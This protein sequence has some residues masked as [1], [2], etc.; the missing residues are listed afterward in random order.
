[1]LLY[2]N[3]EMGIGLFASSLPA[4]R[5]FYR[6]MFKPDHSTGKGSTP[7]TSHQLAPMG[8]SGKGSSARRDPDDIPVGDDVGKDQGYRPGN[9]ERLADESSDKGILINAESPSSEF[10]EPGK[11]QIRVDHTFE[12][13]SHNV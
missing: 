9:W 13:A 12:V 11:K 3:I 1:M 8:R 5:R 2:S 10:V 4:V 7:H 6:I